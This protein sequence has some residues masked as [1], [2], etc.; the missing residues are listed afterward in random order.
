MSERKRINPAGAYIIRAAE[1]RPQ[2]PEARRA[3]SD[4]APSLEAQLAALRVQRD[5]ALKRAEVLEERLSHCQ[6]AGS[7]AVGRQAEWRRRTEELEREV[8]RLRSDCDSLRLERDGL[9]HIDRSNNEFL[10][11]QRDELLAMLERVLF[12][13]QQYSDRERPVFSQARALLDRSRPPQTGEK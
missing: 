6:A 13:A 10:I 7:E 3:M 5:A 8:E 1:T 9:K 11:G 2:R 12:V 4:Q